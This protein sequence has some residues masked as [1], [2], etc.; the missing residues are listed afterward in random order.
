MVSEIIAGDDQLVIADTDVGLV[1]TP[2]GSR[3]HRIN[4]P[5]AIRIVR[6]G[7][8][9]D[10]MVNIGRV[11]YRG[12]PSLARSIVQHLRVRCVARGDLEERY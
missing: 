3:G 8:C 10:N 12:E 7:N 1:C 11:E 9:Q 2:S 4:P 6:G 5:E